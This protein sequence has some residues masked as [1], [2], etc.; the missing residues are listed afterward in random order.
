MTWRVDNNTALHTI[1]NK[2]STKSWPLSVL[3]CSILTRCLE[4]NL[5]LEPVRVSSEEN[6]VASLFKSVA[7]WSLSD[8]AATKMFTR[9]GRPD[10]DLMASDR[11][12]KAP[13]FFSWTRADQETWGIDSLTQDVLWNQFELPYCFP[14]IPLLQQVLDKARDRKWTE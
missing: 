6:L 12:R 3:S 1:R 10:V 14:P 2:G 8:S 4:R 9:W 5:V 7:N 11:S 13:I